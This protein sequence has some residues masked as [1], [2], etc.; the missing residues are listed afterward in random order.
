VVLESFTPEIRAGTMVL[1]FKLVSLNSTKVGITSSEMM[2]IQ[3]HVIISVG[4]SYKRGRH[5][6]TRTWYGTKNIFELH[7]YMSRGSDPISPSKSN[8]VMIFHW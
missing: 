7:I 8:L 6:N 1:L 3:S 5:T 4:F 2:F